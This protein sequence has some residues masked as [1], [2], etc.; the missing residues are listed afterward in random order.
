MG[1][2]GSQSVLRSLAAEPR[3]STQRAVIHTHFLTRNQLERE[4]RLL[5]SA[6]AAYQGTPL[7]E[8]W[9]KPP[10]MWDGQIVGA[11]VTRQRDRRWD[12]I[13]LVRDPVARNVS[14][15]FEKLEVP[16]GYDWFERRQRL[17][18]DELLSELAPLFDR[19]VLDPGGLARLD[20]DPLHWF[21]FEMA[22]VFGIDIFAS[23]FSPNVG[24]QIYEGE[25][26]RLLLIRTA[27][28]S[29]WDRRHSSSSSASRDPTRL[30]E[31]RRPER[32]RLDLRT[33]QGETPLAQ[34]QLDATYG[35]RLV[36]SPLHATGD[37]GD[38]VTLG[39]GEGNWLTSRTSTLAPP[40]GEL[41]AARLP[42]ISLGESACDIQTKAGGTGPALSP[43]DNS[44]VGETGTG[45]ID[46]KDR[47]SPSSL[48]TRSK[49]TPAGVWA[50]TFPT[51]ASITAATSDDV[52]LHDHG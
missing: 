37:R 49:R 47:H 14:L 29:G 13:T 24:W 25:R 51:K 7:P 43:P 9:W 2:V 48:T 46:R 4:N 3:I 31:R 15:F 50:K 16:I 8:I 11:A 36:K 42:A 44:S 38:A 33:V 52:G 10:F 23:P 22:P 5:A 6:R 34:E 26:A 39:D 30:G 28:L 21:D 27:D 35:S 41:P 18:D 45:V 32:A 1:K 17:S 20:V 19:H 40:S 12:V